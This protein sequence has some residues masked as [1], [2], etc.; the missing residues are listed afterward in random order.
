MHFHTPRGLERKPTAS[1]LGVR[2]CRHAG[3]CP[4]L[5]VIHFSQLRRRRSPSTIPPM[6]ESHDATWSLAS[7]PCCNPLS[8]SSAPPAQHTCTRLNQRASPLLC[9]E[10][11]LVTVRQRIPEGA[12]P[13]TR[14]EGGWDSVASVSCHFPMTWTAAEVRSHCKDSRGIF[15]VSGLPNCVRTHGME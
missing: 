9:T 5:H 3:V 6:S 2:A 10:T 8:P 4:C 15:R 12:G 11:V 1:F 7:P 13:G 14:E